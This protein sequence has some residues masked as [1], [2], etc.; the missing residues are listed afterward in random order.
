[1]ITGRVQ[2]V[3]FRWFARDAALREGA[4]G[5][6]KNLTDGSVEAEVEGDAEAVGRFESALRRGP[7]ASRVDNVHVDDCAPGG[8]NTGFS[9][10]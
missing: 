7:S 2:G 8:R 10:R 9:I 3:G 1:M 5:W 6:V 4:D